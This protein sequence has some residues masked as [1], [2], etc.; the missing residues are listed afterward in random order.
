MEVFGIR[1]LNLNTVCHWW[2]WCSCQVVSD[3]CDPMDDSQAS[4]SVCRIS[5]ARI[6]EWV[7]RLLCPGDLPDPGIKPRSPALQ[8]DSLLTEL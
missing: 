4:S 3:A 6:L 7:A 2:W 8:A 1:T 5:Q